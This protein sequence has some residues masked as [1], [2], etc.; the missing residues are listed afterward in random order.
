[1]FSGEPKKN[2]AKPTSDAFRPPPQ[3]AHGTMPRG[4]IVASGESRDE[5]MSVCHALEGGAVLDASLQAR[6][7]LPSCVCLCRFFETVLEVR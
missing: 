3:Y 5:D 7:S 1:M 4:P 6:K 2:A